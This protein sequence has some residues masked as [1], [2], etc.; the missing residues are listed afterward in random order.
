MLDNT[1]SIFAYMQTRETDTN[2]DV[3]TFPKNRANTAMMEPNH[4]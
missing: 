2:F 1:Y 4:A 3:K